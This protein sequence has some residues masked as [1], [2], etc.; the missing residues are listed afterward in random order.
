VPPPHPP[1]PELLPSRQM[2]EGTVKDSNCIGAT[3]EITLSSSH[4]VV[5]LYSDKYMKILYSALNY[6]PTGI[7][8]PC[9]DMKGW[10][11]RITY[12]PAK[13]QPNQGEMVAVDLIK[14]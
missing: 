13:A 9:V 4:G 8:D 5:Q 2:A 10:H 11:A 6:T 12:H 14:D 7:L 3:L 1:R